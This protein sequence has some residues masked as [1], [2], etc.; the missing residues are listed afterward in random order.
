MSNNKENDTRKDIENFYIEHHSRGQNFTVKHFK[1]EKV[2]Q[3][4]IYSIIRRVDNNIS[5][6]RQRGSAVNVKN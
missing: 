1:K 5:L 3:S 6:E 4:T 2:P